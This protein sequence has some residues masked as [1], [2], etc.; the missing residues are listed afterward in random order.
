MVW[1]FSVL[2]K[3][4]YLTETV[5]SGRS[6][7][8]IPPNYSSTTAIAKNGH[9]GSAKFVTKVMARLVGIGGSVGTEIAKSLVRDF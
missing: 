2:G 9:P 1:A 6:K 4:V 3:R 7:M 5:K 8:D